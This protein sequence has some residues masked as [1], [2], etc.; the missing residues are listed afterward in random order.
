MKDNKPIEKDVIMNVLIVIL[1][2]MIAITI[3]KI[4]G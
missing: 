4:G 3:Y 2:I 1:Y